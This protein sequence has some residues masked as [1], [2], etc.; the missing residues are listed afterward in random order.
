ME[1]LNYSHTGGQ[2]FVTN[3]KGLREEENRMKRSSPSVAKV[4]CQPRHMIQPLYVPAVNPA[5]DRWT[6]GQKPQSAITAVIFIRHLRRAVDDSLKD[7][8]AR[9]ESNQPTISTASF[10]QTADGSSAPWLSEADW[11]LS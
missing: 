1:A 10:P 7:T 11:T 6:N 5:A 3:L 2:L 9:R 4:Y 8:L